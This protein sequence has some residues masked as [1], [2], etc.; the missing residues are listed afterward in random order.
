MR[1]ALREALPAAVLLINCDAIWR[2]L[3]QRP[4]KADTAGI[5]S[6]ELNA[7]AIVKIGCPLIFLEHASTKVYARPLLASL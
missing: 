2:T 1:I 3:R 6:E 5:M 4:C 7:Q